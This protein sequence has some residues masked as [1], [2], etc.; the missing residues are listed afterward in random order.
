MPR[1]GVFGNAFDASLA[2]AMIVGTYDAAAKEGQEFKMPVRVREV[3]ANGLGEF[4]GIKGV[5]RDPR[6]GEAK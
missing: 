5:A 3:F 4:T 6:T 2:D 1:V